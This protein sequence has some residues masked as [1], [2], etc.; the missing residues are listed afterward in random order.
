M[1]AVHAIEI[2]Q[3]ELSDGRFLS[4]KNLQPEQPQFQ[5]QALIR[6]PEEAETIDPK[7][8]TNILNHIHFT[9]GSVLVL[10]HQREQKKPIVMRARPEPYAEDAFLCRWTE[11]DLAHMAL[12]EFQFECLIID[13]GESAILVRPSL[14]DI[15]KEYLA[16]NIAEAGH[17][18]GHR[19]IKRHTA[20]AI[21][22]QLTQS[23]FSTKG[24]LADFSPFGF[25]IRLNG[26]ASGSFDRFDSS[27][28]ITVNLFKGQRIFYSGVCRYVRQLQKPLL[29]EIVLTPADRKYKRFKKKH[30][31][32]FRQ[33]LVP[34]PVL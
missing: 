4:D 6:I 3:K 18:A 27:K 16:I 20:K 29:R 26:E 21:S 9:D 25:C 17:I 28:P 5:H 34:S 10:L 14:V 11:N 1:E 22:V 24:D 13:D 19:Q 30:F 7:A 15:H 2:F 31:R 33:E 32:N 23:G 8:L 12:E